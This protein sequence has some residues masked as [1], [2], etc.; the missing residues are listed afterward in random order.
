MESGQRGAKSPRPSAGLRV[1]GAAP[2]GETTGSSAARS[3]SAA[4]G[5]GRRARWDAPTL[6]TIASPGVRGRLGRA[7]GGRALGES[8]GVRRGCRRVP[9]VGVRLSALRRARAPL[10][11]R[12][13]LP[14]PRP[15]RRA[16][17]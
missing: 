11:L 9:A 13:E 3:S 17:H 7:A 16:P 14:A 10:A 8:P 1:P 12:R 5:S 2:A 4:Q 15:G 6:G